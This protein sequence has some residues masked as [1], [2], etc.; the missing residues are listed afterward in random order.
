MLFFSFVF[1]QDNEC[2]ANKQKFPYI[3]VGTF[4]TNMDHFQEWNDVIAFK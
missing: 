4:P 1:A 2:L 3:N